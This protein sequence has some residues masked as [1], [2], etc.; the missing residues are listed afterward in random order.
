MEEDKP[1]HKTGRKTGKDRVIHLPADVTDEVRAIATKRRGLIWTTPRGH[2]WCK[3]NR[4]IHL[5][6]LRNRPAV[7]A[8]CKANAFDPTKIVPM[9]F[10]H[11]F[12]TRALLQG[13]P[14]AVVAELVGNTVPVLMRHYGHL[15][16]N[17]QALRT[18]F[19]RISQD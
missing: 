4:S 7:L 14:V 13:I 3:P 18:E 5:T 15:C 19:D 8:W 10:R 17:R 1:G 11:T 6:R 9:S 2:R 12:A 16:V